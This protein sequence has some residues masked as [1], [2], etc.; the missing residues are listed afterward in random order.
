[1]AKILV[2]DDSPMQVKALSLMLKKLGHEPQ[3]ATSAREGIKVVS[4]H[5]P[6]LIMLD[7][8][9]PEMNGF[10][11]V[12]HFHRDPETADIPIVLV[13]GKSQET[14]KQWGMRQGA[15]GYIVKPIIEQELIDC[16][17]ELL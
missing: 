10:E 11:A 2:I 15:K 17:D 16:L 6:D 5:R 4:E 1:M 7:V 13:S 12:R 14:D 8:I 9:M 3:G